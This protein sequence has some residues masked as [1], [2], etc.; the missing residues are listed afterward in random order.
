MTR[1][2]RKLVLT[3]A[4]TLFSLA[5]AECGFRVYLARAAK[6]SDESWRKELHAMNATIYRRSDDPTLVYEPAPST[7]VSMPYGTASFDDQS[8][9]DDREHAL[10]PEPGRTRVALVGDSIV[11]GEDLPLEKTLAKTLERTLGASKWEVLG[12]GVTGYDT[13]QE[14]AWYRRAV[15][16]FHPAIV[17]VVYC[18]ND[19]FIASGPFNKWATPEELRAK[20]DQDALVE[21]LAPV[22]EE[23]IED[24][25]RREEDHAL[26]RLFARARTI[27]RVRRYEH[28]PAYTDEYLLLY[29]QKKNFDRMT[30][31]LAR[32]AND[33]HEDGAAAH[34]VISPILRSWSTYHWSGLE[35]RV[36]EAARTAGFVVHDPLATLRAS[37]REREIRIDSV[38]YNA[39]GTEALAAF[40]AR[41]LEPK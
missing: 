18:M 19:V 12:F 25:S 29:G 31:A 6:D 37:H 26:S 14:E 15:R 33:I 21:R 30:G 38:H 5:L 23:T 28:D 16:A 3:C 17:V 7:S 36:A 1:A 22:R 8:M 2:A 39:Q 13:V 24:L 10:A 40:I 34:L 4:A 27:W 9:R 32:L 35:E 11:W 20:D 41:E